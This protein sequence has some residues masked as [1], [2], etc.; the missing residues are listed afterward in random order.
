MGSQIGIMA[1]AVAYGACRVM[2]ITLPT[3]AMLLV[4]VVAGWVQPMLF[5]D[6]SVG[7][8]APPLDD[9][10]EILQG[11][12]P[13]VDGGKVV[14]VERWATW[15]PPCV[16]S[17]PHLNGLYQ[18]YKGR[19]DFVG[20]T[21]ETDTAKIKVKRCRCISNVLCAVFCM[22]SFRLPRSHILPLFYPCSNRSHSFWYPR[23][24]PVISFLTRH[25]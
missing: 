21:D 19:V 10:V 4:Y 1:V 22:L 8:P 16:A 20:V 7:E 14:V 15:C 5:P 12:R 9:S 13:K 6:K 3:W 24:P 11:S 23:F 18:K 25:S 17:I 2:N